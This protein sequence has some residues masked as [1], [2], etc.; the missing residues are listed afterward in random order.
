[1][2]K[3]REYRLPLRQKKSASLVDRI[4]ENFERITTKS[5]KRRTAERNRGKAQEREAEMEEPVRVVHG[6]YR[7]KSAYETYKRF[8]RTNT[9]PGVRPRR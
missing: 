8:A 4:V 1:M 2:T 7:C 9:R 6:R 3:V 5:G